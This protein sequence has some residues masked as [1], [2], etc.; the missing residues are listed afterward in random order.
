M[1]CVCTSKIKEPIAPSNFDTLRTFCNEKLPENTSFSILTLGHEKAEKYLKNIDITKAT[2]ADSIGPTLLKL[3]APYIS[4]CLTFIC[5]QSIINSIFPEKWKEGKV[6]PLYK[7]GPK[8]DANNYKPISVLPVSSKLLEKHVHDSLM[9][10][11]S[12]NSLLHSTPTGFRPNHSCETSL[13]QMINKWLDAINSSQMIGMVMID[14]R[15]A[16]DLVEHTLLLKKLKYYKISEETISWF[17]SYLLGRKHKVFVNNTLSESENILC[18]VPQGSILGPLLFLLFIN[19]LPLDI[20]NVLTDLYADDT[21]LYYIGKSQACIEEQLQ[22]AMLKLS[23]WCKENGMLIN[24]TKTKVMLI[25]TP[26]KPVYLNN[27][28]L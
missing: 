13:L 23:Q 11:L 1:F 6:T 20:N 2:G 28:N 4:K 27:Y 22:T 19:D 9:V 3:A 24:T 10:Y 12:S 5:N 26:Q 21:T 14:F 15:S 7:N 16:F 17:S 25:T 18:G 8:D